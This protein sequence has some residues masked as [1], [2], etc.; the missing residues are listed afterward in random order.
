MARFYI[1][2]KPFP[3]LGSLLRTAI[4]TRSQSRMDEEPTRRARR[5]TH[6]TAGGAACRHLSRRFRMQCGSSASSCVAS[7]VGSR[8]T[9]GGVSPRDGVQSMTGSPHWSHSTPPPPGPPRPSPLTQPRPDP[10]RGHSPLPR[11]VGSD[12]PEPALSRRR[13]EVP[14]GMYRGPRRDVVGRGVTALGPDSAIPSKTKG[15][16]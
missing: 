13:I 2:F 7:A 9:A 14:S 6:G 4:P 5:E 16:R 15:G 10:P 12:P 11:H 1:N 8:G 3:P